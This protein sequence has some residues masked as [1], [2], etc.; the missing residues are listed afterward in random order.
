MRSTARS[1]PVSCRDLVAGP[2][3][4]LRNGWSPSRKNSWLRCIPG[5]RKKS[6]LEWV[7]WHREAKRAAHSPRCKLGNPA[8]WHMALAAVHGWAGHLA[9]KTNSPPR[10][11]VQWCSAE[12]WE[13]MKNRGLGSADQTWRHPKKMW[14]WSFENALVKAHGVWLAQRG[15]S[16]PRE[17]AKPK[18][19]VCP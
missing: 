9:R 7:G 2:V 17:K 4:E 13:I 5:G 11:A 1:C 8:L 6:D 3:G 18:T 12:W 10:A 19:N 15:S 14:I 16:Q